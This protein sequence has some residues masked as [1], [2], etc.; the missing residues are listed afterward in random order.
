MPT[1]KEA[2][3]ALVA[4]VFAGVVAIR[5]DML[6][7]IAL[8]LAALLIV[9]VPGYLISAMFVPFGGTDGVGRL[10][11]TLGVGLAA[12][13][14]GGL[15]LQVTPVGVSVTGWLLLVLLVVLVAGLWWQ[16][17]G[18]APERLAVIAGHA[19]GFR[20]NP[21]Q[22][23]MVAISVAL[24]C[25]AVVVSRGSESALRG[26]NVT[27]LWTAP[28]T[29]G[30]P[31]AIDVWI[32]NLEGSA[33]EYRMEASSGDQSIGTWRTTLADGNRWSITVSPPPDSTERL[34]VR[35]YLDSSE[36]VYRELEIQP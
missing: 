29:S 15:V 28:A 21:G 3:L 2:A 30:E 19:A 27:Q 31:G 13:I 1:R 32:R 25:T 34:D 7:A 17:R 23:A 22:I 14:L 36:T 16:P 8:L 33:E 35:L 9:A 18:F 6:P 10:A 24:T 20:P 4:S 12:V 5:T 26:P 11:L